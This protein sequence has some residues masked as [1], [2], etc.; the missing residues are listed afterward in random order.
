MGDRF[1]IADF[2]SPIFKAFLS[3]D[4]GYVDGQIGQVIESYETDFPEMDS[5]SIVLVGCGDAR[6]A[7][8]SRTTTD[9]PDAIRRHFYRLFYWETDIGLAD[10]GNVRIG[11]TLQDTY[12]ALATVVKELTQAGKTVIILGGSQDLTLA[13]YRAYGQAGK[14]IEASGI[15]ARIDLYTDSVNPAEHFL[16]EMLT[17]SPNF[18]RHYNH[19]GFQSYYVH[20]G[21]LETLDKLRFDCY[22][23]GSVKESIDE[24][25]PVLRNS[26]LL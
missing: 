13:Q 26:H 7:D 5:A 14:I 9:A 15:D 2:L 4:Q 17:G 23:V 16:M 22:R 10:V 6:G 3:N 8:L 25:E 18:I 24:M 21:M 19:I 11:H 12:A 1:R 20:P